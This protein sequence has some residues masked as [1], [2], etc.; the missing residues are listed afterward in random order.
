MIKTN[1]HTHTLY[2]DGKNSPEEVIF[3][4]IEKKFDILGF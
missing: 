1:Y 4:G 2:C 3:T